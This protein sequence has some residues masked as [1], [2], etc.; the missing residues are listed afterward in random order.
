VAG[1][2]LEAEDVGCGRERGK[3]E[4]DADVGHNDL[5]PV[6]FVK[7]DCIG[8]EVVGVLGVLELARRVLEKVRLP[9]EELLDDEI[10]EDVDRGVAKS[11]RE[12]SAARRGDV[13]AGKVL[14]CLIEGGVALMQAGSAGQRASSP[15]RMCRK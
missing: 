6:A 12:L 2:V 10:T 4:A 7:D 9:A 11:L 15:T 5:R 14:L 8:V 3:E 1:D 13:D